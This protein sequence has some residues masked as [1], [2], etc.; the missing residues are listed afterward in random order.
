MS[1]E[2]RIAI[3]AS[4]GGPLELVDPVTSKTYVVIAAEH[5][6]R[7]STLL[8]SQGPDSSVAYSAFAQVAGP[9]GWDDP[10]MDVYEK[11]GARRS[12]LD[13]SASQFCDAD[14]RKHPRGE[15]R[16]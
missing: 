16:G 2:L 8:D 13:Q 5:Y 4:H 3:E 12:A 1:D 7:I 15:S 9:A 14:R 10:E 6:L 11:V